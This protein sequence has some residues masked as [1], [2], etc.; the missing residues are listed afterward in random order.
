MPNAPT[1]EQYLDSLDHPM[2]AEVRALRAAILAADPAI[3]E[4]VKWNA[5]SFYT[6][7]HFATFSLRPGA[8][9]QVVLHRGARKREAPAERLAVPDPLG[10]LVWKANDRAIA[11]FRDMAAV[12]AGRDALAGVVRAWLAYV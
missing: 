5:P 3:R 9:V 6:T 2:V 8:G 1:V 11:T 12:R 10:L 7:E 4:E